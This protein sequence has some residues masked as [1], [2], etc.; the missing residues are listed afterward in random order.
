[1]LMQ[2][3]NKALM[4]WMTDRQTVCHL[5]E[6][7]SRQMDRRMNGFML[8]WIHAYSL[9]MNPYNEIWQNYSNKQRNRNNS[10]KN[11]RILTA[12]LNSVSLEGL[13]S[14]N[15][16]VATTEALRGYKWKTSRWAL[17]KQRHSSLGGVQ[18]FGEHSGDCIK[19]TLRDNVIGSWS[20]TDRPCQ[21]IK[22]SVNNDWQSDWFSSLL[23][24]KMEVFWCKLSLV[25]RTFTHIHTHTNKHLR[26]YTVNTCTNYTHTYSNTAN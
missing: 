25:S 5:A 20:Q 7:L 3:G 4:L 21:I 14:Q 2:E 13:D 10:R 15:L 22:N 8:R 18:G 24:S 11:P 12:N 1:M 9:G 16:N 26:A 17:R 23:P 19:N 6:W